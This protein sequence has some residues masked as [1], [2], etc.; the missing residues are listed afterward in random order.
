[1]S[2]QAKKRGTPGTPARDGAAPA[3]PPAA[4]PEPAAVVA[5]GKPP[6]AGKAAP[7]AA[8]RP[9]S[10]LPQTGL[11]WSLLLMFVAC[12]WY[13]LRTFAAGGRVEPSLLRKVRLLPNASSPT[14]LAPAPHPPPPPPPPPP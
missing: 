6:A 9:F 13:P 2:S 7:V 3:A 10:V 1:M 11:E 14:I 4:A 12:M 8:G 5:N